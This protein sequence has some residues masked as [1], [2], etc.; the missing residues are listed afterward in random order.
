[1]LLF[2]ERSGWLVLVPAIIRRMIVLAYL[3]VGCGVG[4]GVG[5]APP[6]ALKINDMSVAENMNEN[7]IVLNLFGIPQLSY[8]PSSRWPERSHNSTQSNTLS[9]TLL[10]FQVPCVVSYTTLHISLWLSCRMRTPSIIVKRERYLGYV[11]VTRALASLRGRGGA[12]RHDERQRLETPIANYL[13][14]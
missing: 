3:G 11:E 12:S 4:C 6:A 14:I 8:T 10:Y 5:S 9:L 7:F 13:N 1:M 2:I